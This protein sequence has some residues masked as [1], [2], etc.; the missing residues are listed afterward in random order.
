MSD[1]LN[2]VFMGTPDFAVPALQALHERS[3]HNVVAVYTQPPRPK[4]RGKQEQKSA[5]H[6]Y[7]DTHDIPV[8]HPVS[9]KK[10]PEA[11]EELKA[12]KP[13]VAVVAAYG[14]ILP[15]SVLDIP[16]YGCL[17]IHGSLLPQWRGAS[18]IQHAIWK[19]D[20]TSGVTIMQMEKGLDT[21]PMISKSYA[22][23]NLQTTASS[24]HDVLSQQGA[25]EIIKVVDT[26]AAQGKLEAEVQNDAL[27]SYAPML[28]REDGIINWGDTA[29]A[30]HRQIR[31]L[32]PWPGTQCAAPEGK[33]LK[34]LGA[35]LTDMV[36]EDMAAGTL[37][38]RH[39]HIVC[40]DKTVLRLETVK[41]ENSKAM[42]I[43]SAINGHYI[44]VGDRLN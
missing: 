1:C 33:V 6:R 40:G 17:N 21:G 30:I 13:D 22:D 14:L 8:Y 32:N 2:I 31:A 34:I 35:Q 12:L 38:D 11:V 18:P 23:I 44:K 25:D 5:T 37:I 26:L 28:S 10:Q 41:P 7:A 36:S 19:G 9:F 39:G 43:A 16:V 42:D 4:G 3:A 20:Q 24:L 29:T 15:Q 27:S